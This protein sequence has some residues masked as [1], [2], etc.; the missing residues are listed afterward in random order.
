MARFV[1]AI[2]LPLTVEEAF[3]YLADF[4]Q[5]AEWDPS[6]VEAERLTDGAVGLGSRF[7]VVVSF[8]GRRL[9]YEYE[10]TTYERPSRLVLTGGDESLRSVD[11][12][13]FVPRKDGTRVGYEARLELAG[14]RKLADPLVDALFQHTARLAA[15]GLRERAAVRIQRPPH[16][17]D[18]RKAGE[19]TTTEK[20]ATA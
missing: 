10:I 19:R 14:I 8:F 13:T 6:V 17:R 18:A 11:E 9:E 1:D 5:T 20:G 12:I 4:S 2:D 15:R 16:A 7:R 3:D